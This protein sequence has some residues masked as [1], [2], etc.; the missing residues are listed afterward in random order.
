MREDCA[1]SSSIKEF[2]AISNDGPEKLVNLSFD[3]VLKTPSFDGRGGRGGVES[4]PPPIFICENNRKSN[5][6]MH[7]VYLF[8]SGSFKD[9]GIFYVFQVLMG[10]GGL[11]THNR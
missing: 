1:F 10:G 8:L 5:K 4:T 7:C 6:I 9:M 2:K 3:G 11:S